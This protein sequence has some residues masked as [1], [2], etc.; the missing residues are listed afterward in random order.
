MLAF[1][2]V[3][4]SRELEAVTL[5]PEITVKDDMTF[6]DLELLEL[7][8]SGDVSMGFKASIRGRDGLYIAKITG[9]SFL[10]WS[11]TEIQM[12]NYLNAPPT[13]PSI[14][15]LEFAIPSMPNPYKNRTYLEENIGLDRDDIDWLVR[16][17]NI[18]IMVMEFLD[19]HRFPTTIQG[20]RVFMRSLL[21][22]LE[23]A[24]SRNVMLCDLHTGNVYFDGET[25]KLFDWNGAFFFQPSVVKMHYYG[26]PN[27]LMPPEAWN[28]TN[29]VHVT[30]SG[31]DI[32]SAGL[33]LKKLVYREGSSI[34]ESFND[35]FDEATDSLL[36]DFMNAMLTKDPHKR[37]DATELLKHPFI[38]EN[39]MNRNMKKSS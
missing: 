29:A 33:L 4:L 7:K 37:P 28:D 20:I 24:H 39:S 16:K 5:L 21:Y 15:K 38:T 18:S 6:D 11:N 23:F 19:N 26:A 1:T 34:S 13:I 2:N 12:F 32:W 14:P 17:D 10:H 8:G 31:F 3:K 9:D 36:K 25:V 22:T 35:S 27:F 30:V